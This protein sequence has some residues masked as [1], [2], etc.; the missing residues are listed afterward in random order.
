VSDCY[1]NVRVQVFADIALQEKFEDTE[2]VIRSRK[3]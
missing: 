1:L 3:S 2:A